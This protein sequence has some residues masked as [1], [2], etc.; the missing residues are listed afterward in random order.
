MHILRDKK[1]INNMKFCTYVV[2]FVNFVL[3]GLVLLLYWK[4]RLTRAA[5]ILSPMLLVNSIVGFF[6]YRHF[7]I[8]DYSADPTGIKILSGKRVKKILPWH[9]FNYV[10]ELN[11]S[12]QNET[13]GVIVCLP[14]PPKPALSKD[15]DCYTFSRKGTVWIDY[16]PEDAQIMRPYY[17]G[18]LPRAAEN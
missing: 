15:Q 4:G 6:Y 11:R 2:S 10:G 1:T 17:R 9:T 18:Q 16:T 14:E 5:L 13:Q 8:L 12:D 7:F 3:A